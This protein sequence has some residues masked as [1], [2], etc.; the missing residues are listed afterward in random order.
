MIEA[1]V[2]RVGV[3]VVCSSKAGFRAG[4]LGEQPGIVYPG[5]S[6]GCLGTVKQ[7]YRAEKNLWLVVLKHP[8]CRSSKVSC[9]EPCSLPAE[10]G[11]APQ[12]E[13]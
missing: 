6:P 4:H 13:C 3:S 10:P 9:A 8:G 1:G 7:R 5:K 12:G 11:S 2:L